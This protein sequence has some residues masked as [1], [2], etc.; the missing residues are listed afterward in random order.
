[1]YTCNTTFKLVPYQKDA[2]AGYLASKDASFLPQKLKYLIGIVPD[3]NFLEVLTAGLNELANFPVPCMQFRNLSVSKKKEKKRGSIP[4]L[5]RLGPLS[6]LAVRRIVVVVVMS[7]AVALS[8]ESRILMCRCSLSG[9]GAFF[10]AMIVQ[11]RV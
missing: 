4:F 5:C 6:C 3:A 2:V 8:R 1:M 9:T 7:T 11:P 10:H